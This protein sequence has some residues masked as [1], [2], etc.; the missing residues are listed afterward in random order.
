MDLDTRVDPKIGDLKTLA[1]DVQDLR[2]P[3]STGRAL[4]R[5]IRPV[6]RRG[7]HASPRSRGRWE[8]CLIVT[9][10]LDDCLGSSGQTPTFPQSLRAEL[11]AAVEVVDYVAISHTSSAADAIR[12]LCPDVYAKTLN[13]RNLPHRRVELCPATIDEQSYARAGARAL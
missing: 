1:A 2:K 6:A 12:L 5:R 9:V 10:T 3:R 13:S 4:P 11:V 8:I 7:H